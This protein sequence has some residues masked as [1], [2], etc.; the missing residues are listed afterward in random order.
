MAI[1]SES[2]TVASKLV[3]LAVLNQKKDKR[4]QDAA[5]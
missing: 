1:F 2:I 3:L 4:L 5:K